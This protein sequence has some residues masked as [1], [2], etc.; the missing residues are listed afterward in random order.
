MSPKDCLGFKAPS[1]I[2]SWAGNQ[3]TV[4]WSFLVNASC[5]LLKVP[6]ELELGGTV[7]LTAG[8]G[9]EVKLD[10]ANGD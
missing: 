4:H 9:K 8:V 7:W 5:M 1:A 2:E 3:G 10:S 6:F